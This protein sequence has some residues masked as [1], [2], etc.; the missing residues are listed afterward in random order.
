QRAKIEQEFAR[1]SEANTNR[2]E[3][4]E[5]QKWTELGNSIKSSFNAALDGAI[6]QGRSFGQFMLQVAQGVAKAF[7]QMGETILENWIETEIANVA[8]TKATQGASALGQIS[9]AAGVA[10]ANAFADCCALQSVG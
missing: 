6:F 7:L 4:V 1:Q 8:T 10:G 9:D 2:L 5:A 3:L